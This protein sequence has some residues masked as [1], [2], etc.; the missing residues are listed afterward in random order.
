M[1]KNK[2]KP[3]EF[4]MIAAI[5]SFLFFGLSIFFS[6]IAENRYRDDWIEEMYRANLMQTEYISLRIRY[7]VLLIPIRVLGEN[8]ITKTL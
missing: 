2:Q 7:M 4:L 6:T 1:K 8:L 3:I 5:L